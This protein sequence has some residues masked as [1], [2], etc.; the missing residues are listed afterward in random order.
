MNLDLQPTLQNE[1]VRIEP[2]HANDF[3]RLYQVASDPLIWEQHPN[4]NRYER[5]VFQAFFDDA[6]AG[7]AAFLA[8]DAKTNQLIGSSRYYDVSVAENSIAIGYTFLARAYWGGN[9]N[10]A[11]K[12]L[13]LDHAFQVADTVVFH[14]GENNIRSQKGTGKLGAVKVGEVEKTNYGTSVTI[15]NYTYHLPRAKWEQIKL[16]RKS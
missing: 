6:L 4:K 15:I 10:W 8:F 2:L 1:W 3:E 12:S 16:D 9:Y 13:M 14:I 11:L 5:D 7:G